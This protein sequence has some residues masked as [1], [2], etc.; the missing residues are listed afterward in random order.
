MQWA[1]TMVLGVKFRGITMQFL[2]L[3]MEEMWISQEKGEPRFSMI[4]L[5]QN[6][7]EDFLNT[8]ICNENQAQHFWLSRSWK[9]LKN[10][11]FQQVSGDVDTA[12]VGTRVWEPLRLESCAIQAVNYHD[13]PGMR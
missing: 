12:D 13:L 9:G 1:I 10:V 6:H 5:H 2:R 8:G 11:H 7:L 3:I 4:S